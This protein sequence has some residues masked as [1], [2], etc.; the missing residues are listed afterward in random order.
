MGGFFLGCLVL[1]EVRALV[2]GMARHFKDVPS[3][4]DKLSRAVHSKRYDRVVAHCR[5]LRKWGIAHFDAEELGARLKLRDDAFSVL[6]SSR[7]TTNADYYFDLADAIVFDVIVGRLEGDDPIAVT[8]EYLKDASA[9]AVAF[10]DAADAFIAEQTIERWGAVR[11][12][13]SE[14]AR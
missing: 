12:Q 11:R 8:R 9:S 2:D 14:S 4:R 7:G 10:L 1:V 6:L 5:D 3:F 13:V